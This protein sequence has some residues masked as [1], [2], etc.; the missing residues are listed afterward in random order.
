MVP[1]P[2]SPDPV[3]PADLDA[4]TRAL[5]EGNRSWVQ[6]TRQAD[7]DAFRRLADNHAPPFFVVACCDAR[8]PLEALVDA[9]PGHLFVHRNV[10]NQ[11]RPDDPAVAASLQFAVAGL[12]VRHLV[13]LGHSRCGGVTAALEPGTFPAVDE[14]VAPVRRLAEGLRGELDQVG[15]GAERVDYLARRHVIRQLEN[16]L[17]QEPVREAL[18]DPERAFRLHGWFYRLETGAI[19]VLELPMERWRDEGLWP[20]R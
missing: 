6:A 19:E 12:G 20:E 9:D 13:V 18:R 15:A 1:F 8:K 5:L 17:N 10:A 3:S 14:W 2:Q 11:V 16:A 4:E 7:P